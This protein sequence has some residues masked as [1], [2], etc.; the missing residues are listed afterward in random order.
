MAHSPSP[1]NLERKQPALVSKALPGSDELVSVLQRTASCGVADSYR[2]S[3]FRPASLSVNVPS[4]TH[5]LSSM[6]AVGNS[7]TTERASPAPM[8][9]TGTSASLFSVS[10]QFCFF[11]KH[12][13]RSG[14]RA[15]SN[16]MVGGG[17]GSVWDAATSLRGTSSLSHRSSLLLMPPVHQAQLSNPPSITSPVTGG[18]ASIPCL[19]PLFL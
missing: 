5:F 13:R 10:P 11:D 12:R 15:C 4:P 16:R 2:L 18:C 19:F 14:E 6:E 9:T 17:G 3:R 8:L 7:I 1:S